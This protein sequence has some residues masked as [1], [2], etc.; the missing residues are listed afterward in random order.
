[1]EAVRSSTALGF[2]GVSVLFDDDDPSLCLFE[3]DDEYFEG[4]C[5][6]EGLLDEDDDEC[7]D[8]DLEVEDECLDEEEE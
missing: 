6:D 1:M 2:V 7:P 4:E 3:D 8:D 5:E